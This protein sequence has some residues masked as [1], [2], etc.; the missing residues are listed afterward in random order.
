LAVFLDTSAVAK[1]YHRE[2]GSE[3]V[4]RIVESTAG[5]CFI[6]R[7]GVLEMHSVL[8]LKERTGAILPGESRPVLAKFRGGI[9]RR[10][11]RIVAIAVR[12]YLAAESSSISTGPFTVCAHWTPS[13]RLVHW[14]YTKTD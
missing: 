6:S 4:E 10:R 9:R 13:N 8:A 7:L 11:L 3:F 12:H 5:N 2:I 14:I 1:L